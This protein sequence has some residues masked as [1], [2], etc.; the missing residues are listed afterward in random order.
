[1]IEVAVITSILLALVAAPSPS[2]QATQPPRRHVFVN[3]SVVPM[4]RERI[5]SGQTVVVE[6]DRIVA[7]G[8]TGS[9][10]IPADAV[11]I[12]G[13]GKFLIPG[14]AEM[15]AHIP[16][17]RQVADSTIERIL[18]LFALNGVTTVRGMLGDPRHLPL[19]DRAARGE[20]LSPTIYSSSPSVN[21]TTMRTGAAAADSVIKYRQAGYDFLKIHP[22]LSRG[23]FDTIAATAARVGIR[24][25]GH[26]PLDVGIERAIEARYAS[27]DHFDGV[28]EGLVPEI[29]AFTPQE[30]GF[31]GLGLIDRADERR[32]P[33]LAAKAKAAGVWVVPTET[34]MRHIVGNFAVEEMRQWPEMK[35]LSAA[36]LAGWI[37]TTSA[38]RGD[39]G[40]TAAAK[41]RYLEFRTKLIKGFHDAGVGFLLGSDAPQVWNV[42]G[43]SVR[44]ELGYLVD[45]GLT[46]FQA[47]ES[48][49]RNVAVFFGT[50][51]VTGTIAAGKRADLVLLDG[52]PLQ[53]IANVGRQ[54]GVMVRGRWLDRAE[55][56]RRL[57]AIEAR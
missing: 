4:D 30:D 12:E 17:G 35:Y 54:S 55:I 52:N 14:L 13:R 29:R 10:A 21:G 56:A 33:A 18:A 41:V 23:V 20:L 31:F 15:H 7:I 46:P 8:A 11:R 48:G 5:L 47:L 28:I 26:V 38:M 44:R 37:R 25:A 49:T 9:V 16:P 22:G 53:D 57:A 34:L 2:I 19:R 50:E 27:V 40:I 43:F 51:A 42:P 1:M 24:F 3:V 36:E 6:G 32:I 39:T 45:A